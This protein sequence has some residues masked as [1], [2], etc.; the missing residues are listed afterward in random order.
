MK[1][2]NWIIQKLPISE[3][4]IPKK[5]N[6]GTKHSIFGIKFIIWSIK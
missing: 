5:W 1:I 3:K 6:V 2:F 4:D